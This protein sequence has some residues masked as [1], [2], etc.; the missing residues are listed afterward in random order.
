MLNFCTLFN[1]FYLIYGLQLYNCLIKLR[2]NFHLYIYAF[3]ERTFSYFKEYALPNLT[4]IK[5]EDFEDRELLSIKSNRSFG[6]YCWTCTPSIIKHAI[7]SFNLES[8]IY[9]DS[10]L[11]FFDNPQVLIDE[12][13]NNSVLIT[14]H[15]YTKIYD[16]SDLSG[17]YCVQFMMFKNDAKGMKVLNWWRDA[18]IEWCFSRFEDGKFGD[19][20]Y[21]DD[22]L[23]RFEGVHSLRH[24]GGGVAPWNVQQYEFVKNGDRIVGKELSTG[25]FFPLI[26]F[27]FHG[28]KFYAEDVIKLT[29][30]AY[31]IS[32]GARDLIYKDYLKGALKLIRENTDFLFLSKIPES[33]L[34]KIFL[35][36]LYF[37]FKTQYL[38]DTI[39]LKDYTRLLSG[40]NYFKNS[41][42]E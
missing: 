21:L 35:L 14:E 2:V 33:H 26:F 27:H 23:T 30:E 25:N 38:I 13:G 6:E 41:K 36:S 29:G 37:R 31:L 39:K 22:W 24:L 42:F 1:S 8:C 28:L 40:G 4:V 7:E 11:Y 32:K 20:K 34:N 19:Q 3:D 18:C 16:Q 12:M 17:I 15:R 5:L 10:D 9:V